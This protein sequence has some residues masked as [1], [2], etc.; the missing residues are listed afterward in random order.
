MDY[1]GYGYVAL[2]AKNVKVGK[3]PASQQSKD[4][5]KAIMTVIAAYTATRASTPTTARPLPS[6]TTRSPTRPGRP[7]RSPTT[8]TRSRIPPT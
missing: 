4:L 8:A 5:R 2:G 3:D 1:R 6:S 7:C